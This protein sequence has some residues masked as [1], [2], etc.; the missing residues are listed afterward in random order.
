MCICGQMAFRLWC[1]WSSPPTKIPEMMEFVFKIICIFSPLT[2]E[3]GFKL[4]SSKIIVAPACHYQN[5]SIK[6]SRYSD[7]W[8]YIFGQIQKYFFKGHIVSRLQEHGRM[9]FNLLKLFVSPDIY[10]CSICT[11]IHPTFDTYL[12]LLRCISDFLNIS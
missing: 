11:Y 6:P 10:I 7:L 9:I 12:L 2:Y 5:V 4:F 1:W 3:Q 8:K